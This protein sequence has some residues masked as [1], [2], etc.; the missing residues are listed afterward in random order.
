M[1]LVQCLQYGRLFFV[2]VAVRDGNGTWE[3]VRDI[4]KNADRA[5]AQI[6]KHDQKNIKFL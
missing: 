2:E 6:V 1:P 5:R 4:A 3:K